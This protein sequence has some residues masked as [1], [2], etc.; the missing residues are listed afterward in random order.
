MKVKTGSSECLEKCC[1][2]EA[3]KREIQHEGKHARNARSKPG[4]NS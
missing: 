1:G 4:V 3:N 2:Q